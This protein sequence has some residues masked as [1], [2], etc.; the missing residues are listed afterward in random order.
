MLE[1][2]KRGR[3]N[4]TQLENCLEIIFVGCELG[5]KDTLVHLVCRRCLPRLLPKKPFRS[6]RLFFSVAGQELV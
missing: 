5:K 4:G 1:V 2:P 3:R 6:F